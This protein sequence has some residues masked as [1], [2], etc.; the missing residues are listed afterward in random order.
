MHRMFWLQSVALADISPKA[1]RV[2]AA[3]VHFC[4]DET[5]K[6]VPTRETLA[7]FTRMHKTTVSTALTRLA[8]QRA[9]EGV[10]LT[11]R[12]PLPLRWRTRRI[13]LPSFSSE[14]VSSGDSWAHL[15]WPVPDCETLISA[16]GR[17]ALDAHH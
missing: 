9:V 15:T 2:A 12:C 10:K 11:L 14:A 6:C 3:L 8:K 7:T 1:M 13:R 4:N 17:Y 5:G 16:G